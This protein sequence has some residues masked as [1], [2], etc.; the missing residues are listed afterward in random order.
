MLS[1]IDVTSAVAKGDLSHQFTINGNG[2]IMELRC[3]IN[4][5]VEQL[6]T[7]TTEIN[8][9]I[10]DQE[11]PSHK[12]THSIGSNNWENIVDNIFTIMSATNGILHTIFPIF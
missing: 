5:M 6:R 7:F 12:L 8:Q 9:V 3:S 1:V 11:D 10:A 4:D 2:N